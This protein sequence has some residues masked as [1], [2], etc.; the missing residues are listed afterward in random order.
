MKISVFILDDSQVILNSIKDILG[1]SG[2]KDWYLFNNVEDFFKDF[3]E[4]VGVAVLDYYLKEGVTGIDVMKRIQVIN[5]GCKIIVISAQEKIDVILANYKIKF[6]FKLSDTFNDD[7]ITYIS[8]SVK[9][10]ALEIEKIKLDQTITQQLEEKLKK[11]EP[12]SD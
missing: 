7:I 11:Y 8:D 2:I 10:R 3:N 9:E 5:P 6:L 1:D 12:R 4:D